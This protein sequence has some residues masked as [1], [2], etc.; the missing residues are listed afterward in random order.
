MKE[1]DLQEAYIIT[2][3]ETETIEQ[4]SKTIHVL[5]FEEFALR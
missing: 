1:L 5:P 4:D 3:E 2:L